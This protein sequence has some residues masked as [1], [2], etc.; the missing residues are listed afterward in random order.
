[1]S[2]SSSPSTMNNNETT[3]IPQILSHIQDENYSE[4][5][6][7][8]TKLLTNSTT[9]ATNNNH[10][11]ITPSFPKYLQETIEQIHIRTLISLKKYTQVVDYYHHHNNNNKNKSKNF[12]FVEYLYALYKLGRYVKCHDSIQ[13]YLQRNDE[14][15]KNDSIHTNVI[16]HLLAQCQYRL[17]DTQN[18]LQTYTTLLQQD[19]IENID[20]YDTFQDEILTNALAV[21]VSNITNNVGK[22]L[23]SKSSLLEK[24][25]LERLE[26]NDDNNNEEEVLYEFLYNAGTNLLLESTSLTQTKKALDLLQIAEQK[27]MDEY[28]NLDD[29]D[30]NIDGT[31][32]ISACKEKNMGKDIMPIQTNIA[33]AKM[34]LGDSNG[35][36]R[37]YL[38]L[39][40]ALRKLNELDPSY[41]GGGALLAIENNL[42]VLNS[43]R[44][45]SASVFD[46]LKRIPDLTSMD[47]SSGGG[48]S[49]NGT[50]VSG[51]GYQK[52]TPCQ[53]RII[54]YN[55][56]I[57]YHKMN[58]LS[59]CKTVLNSLKKSLSANPKN[60]EASN[61][62]NLSKKKRKSG[63]ASQAIHAPT[64]MNAETILWE[65]RIALLECECISAQDNESKVIDDITSL[66]DR[67]K[68]ELAN[69]GGSSNIDEIYILQ[70]TLAE[71]LL[72][73]SQKALDIK[74]DDPALN[75]DMH[76]SLASTL[77]Q[78]PDS[79][80]QRPAIM[81]TLYSIYS[82]LGFNDKAEL[83]KSTGEKQ[84]SLAEKKRLGD[85]KLRL[86]LYEEAAAIYKSVLD[87]L[88]NRNDSLNDED[89]MECTAGLI[90]AISFFDIDT[91]I[92]YAEEV[93][94]EQEDFDGE[95]LEAMEIPR[96][97]KG[98]TDSSKM[99]KL[100][101]RHRNSEQRYV[102]YQ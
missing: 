43:K 18:A 45:M 47:S 30:N 41:D 88:D 79:I 74:N 23:N 12:L 27:C 37:S 29:D 68:M 85:F 20:Y 90:K 57:L 96:L 100:L 50:S 98:V 14:E 39:I 82:K 84:D 40:L 77:E 3:I 64:A 92:E 58:K 67:I 48:S 91:A 33:L 36:T 42:A 22:I 1:M 26:D 5:L 19:D 62:P 97:S 87:D 94:F 59:E 70:Y 4:L 65:A 51:S 80:R 89:R 16:M 99:R 13:T 69:T 46:L 72:Y 31:E 34:Q 44:S 38:E 75:E 55:R 9:T 8:T 56:A 54:L 101:E 7:L 10:T 71:I 21:K 93:S 66:E 63:G 24:R 95:E 53:L 32:I 17:H 35:S 6:S 49:S 76:R 60:V 78:L 102:C 73:K 81:A 61:Q 83:T 86:G 11:N 52:V 28:E 15:G 25:V 2:S